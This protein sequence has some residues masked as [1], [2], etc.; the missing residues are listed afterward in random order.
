MWLDQVINLF[1]KKPKCPIMSPDRV[2]LDNG[3]FNLIEEF[4]EEFV[5]NSK[6]YSDPIEI[7]GK[8]FRG[9]EVYTQLLFQKLGNILEVDLGQVEFGLFNETG[10]AF[11]DSGVMMVSEDGGDFASSKFTE[12]S[13]G[14]T[15]IL[16]NSGYIKNPS[17]LV[18]SIA[19]ELIRLKL[20]REGKKYADDDVILE[21]V[22]LFFGLGVFNANSSVAKMK[23]W[24]GDLSSGWNIEKGPSQLS[25][26][27]HGYILALFA[28][29]RGENNPP[30]ANSLEKE[31]KKVFYEGLG[32]LKIR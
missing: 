32:Y 4:G 7:T 24:S 11:L 14:S 21:L 23:T 12:Y 10:D 26:E 25:P 30:W 20:R 15:E 6:I 2:V 9:D 16:I 5:L 3:F 29:F 27:A 17:Y 31:V 8:V 1:K 28:S 22:L 13:D 18:V 19:F